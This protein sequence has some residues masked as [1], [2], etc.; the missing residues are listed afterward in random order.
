MTQPSRLSR[1]LPSR[2]AAFEGKSPQTSGSASLGH[3]RGNLL[4]PAPPRPSAPQPPLTCVPSAL[5]P[6]GAPRLQSK[7]ALPD[8]PST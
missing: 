1:N 2:W 4:A 5:L 3:R 6:P 7:P 8:P